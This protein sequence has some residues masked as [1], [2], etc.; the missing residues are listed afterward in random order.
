MHRQRSTVITLLTELLNHKISRKMPA[1][2]MLDT[3]DH[4]IDCRA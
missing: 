4:L 2:P 1:A 3:L